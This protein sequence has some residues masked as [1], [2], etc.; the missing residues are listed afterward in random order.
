[1]D[2]MLNREYVPYRTKRAWQPATNVY[3]SADA[4]AICVELAGMEKQWI[5]VICRD[6]RRVT[7]TGQ[8]SLPSPEHGSELC[9]HVMEIDEGPF[10]RQ[11]D[12]PEPFD[13]ERVGSKY[14]KGLLWITLPKKKTA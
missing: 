11:I 7:V 8:R 14:E 9:V 10:E 5:D 6:D 3:E 13:V 4:Y 2:E 1:M 12:L